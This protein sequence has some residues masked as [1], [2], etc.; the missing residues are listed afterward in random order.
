MFALS[1]NGGAP[2]G[3]APGDGGS[4][5]F[6]D[7]KTSSVGR[8]QRDGT[9]TRYPLRSG[10]QPGAI[11][12]GADGDLWFVDPTGPSIGR[13]TPGGTVTEFRLPTVEQNPMGGPG[14]GSLPMSIAAGPDGAM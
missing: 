12:R 1:H 13:I 10:A 8:L 7:P 9:V 3:V 2:A 6:T 11:A 5:W 4:V 14:L